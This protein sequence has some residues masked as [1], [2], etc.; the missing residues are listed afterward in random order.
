[1]RSTAI[2]VDFERVSTFI[3]RA[4]MG[5]ELSGFG[6]HWAL[7]FGLGTGPGFPNLSSS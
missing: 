4:G 7:S 3:F 6:L 5:S 2:P 1:M